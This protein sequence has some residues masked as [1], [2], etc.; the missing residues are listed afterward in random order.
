MA[1]DE[2]K[3]RADPTP[4]TTKVPNRIAVTLQVA[5]PL[6][7]ADRARLARSLESYFAERADALSELGVAI[8]RGSTSPL[9]QSMTGDLPSEDLESLR[10]TLERDFG[11]R[12]VPIID[13]QVVDPD[14]GA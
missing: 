2:K 1:E 13:H 11:L 8:H 10:E 7:R 9:A 3:T 12:V 5:I 4:G 6:P 14:E